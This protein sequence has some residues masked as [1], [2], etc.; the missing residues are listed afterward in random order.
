[1]TFDPKD[2]QNITFNQKVTK[3]Y[4]GSLTEGF[5]QSM[6]GHAIVTVI[7]LIHGVLV[8]AFIQWIYLAPLFFWM[9]RQGRAETAQGFFLGAMVGCAINGFAFFVTLFSHGH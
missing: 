3:K 8:L 9:R 7:T 1:M 4:D 2:V 6:A 5:I